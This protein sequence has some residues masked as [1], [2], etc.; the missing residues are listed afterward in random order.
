MQLSQKKS[1]ISIKQSSNFLAV[2]QSSIDL[3]EE[4][5][6]IREKRDKQFDKGKDA[7][8]GHWD[9]QRGGVGRRRPRYRERV[10]MFSF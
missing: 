5:M 3:E 2:K 8:F 6:T 7:N 9:G 10:K 1:S 4:R